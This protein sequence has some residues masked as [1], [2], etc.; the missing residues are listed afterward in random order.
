M[1]SWLSWAQDQGAAA[2]EAIQVLYLIP[3]QPPQE[4]FQIFLSRLTGG[5]GI[6]R[7]CG[8]RRHRRSGRGGSRAR[9]G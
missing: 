4:S 8:L 5:S 7:H 2:M 9:T 6:V 3:Y 1:S